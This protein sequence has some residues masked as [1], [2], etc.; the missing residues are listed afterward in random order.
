MKIKLFIFFGILI[1]FIVGTFFIFDNSQQSKVLIED[2]KFNITYTNPA[3]KEIELIAKNVSQSHV[4]ELNKYDCTDFTKAL[5]SNLKQEGYDAYC[6]V[7]DWIGKKNLFHAW[8]EVNLSGE[9]IWVE[10]TTGEIIINKENYKFL[11]RPDKCY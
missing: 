8:T 3:Y 9:I 11:E 4:Y 1:L 10:S 5:V 7:G 6:V 2:K